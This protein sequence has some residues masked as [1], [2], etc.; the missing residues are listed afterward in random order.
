LYTCGWD[1][2][3]SFYTIQVI[4]SMLIY[5]FLFKLTEMFVVAVITCTLHMLSHVLNMKHSHLR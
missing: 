1:M 3:A 4:T 2:V 5:V